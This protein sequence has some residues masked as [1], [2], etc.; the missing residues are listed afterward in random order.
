MSFFFDF[1]VELFEVDAFSGRGVAAADPW[2]D[3]LADAAAELDWLDE[4]M[5]RVKSSNG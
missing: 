5:G 3:P 4:W 2:A 1:F